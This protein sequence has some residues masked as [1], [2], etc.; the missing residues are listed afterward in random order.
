MQGWCVP[1]PSSLTDIYD[2]LMKST[3]KI[4][5][6][7]NNII[8]TAIRIKKKPKKQNVVEVAPSVSNAER[9]SENSDN[10]EDSEDSK[11]DSEHEEKETDSDWE[12]E[13]KDIGRKRKRGNPIVQVGKKAKKV[14][15]PGSYE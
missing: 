2:K 9:D 8:Y 7:V 15:T 6:E 3:G 10:S 14:K 13:E 11:D 12:E 5:S 1:R 4:Q